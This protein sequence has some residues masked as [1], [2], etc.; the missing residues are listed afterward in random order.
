ML[1]YTLVSMKATYRL[2]TP[3]DVPLYVALVQA[4]YREERPGVAIT[5]PQILST[6]REFEHD[7]VKGSVFVFEVEQS[8]VGYCIIANRWSNELGGTVAI[9]DELWV[10]PQRRADGIAEDFIMLL[11]RVAPVDVVAIEHAADRRDRR[12]RDALCRLGFEK[13][14]RESLHLAIAHEPGQ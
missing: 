4:R 8:L 6:V 5:P 11:A 7:R 9:L 2:L 12:G 3:T 10:A 13:S 1:D 14:G